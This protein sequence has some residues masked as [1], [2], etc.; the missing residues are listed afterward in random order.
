MTPTLVLATRNAGKV[1]EIKHLLADLG[2]RVLSLDAFPEAPEVEETG[3]T[4]ADNAELKARAI[5]QSTGH[6]TLADDSGL[7]VDA[8]GGRPGVRSARY[9]GEGAADFELYGK[10][11]IELEGIADENRS[12]RFQCVAAI[13]GPDGTI[14]FFKGICPGRIIHAPRGNNG[15]GFDPVFLPQGYDKTMAE[16]SLEEKNR[17][18]HRSQAVKKACAHLERTIFGDR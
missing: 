5:A 16:I 6:W 8:L 14:A 1:V 9:A 15:F 10:L 7:E 13:A 4:F 3:E 18:S 17:I 2:I 11:L 12:A